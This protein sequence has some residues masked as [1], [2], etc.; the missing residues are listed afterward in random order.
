MSVY[1]DVIEAVATLI[2]N[3]NPYATVTI[4]AMPPTNGIA[5]AWASSFNRL[6]WDKKAAVEFSAVLNG[7]HSNQQT[8]ADGLSDIHTALNF[9]TAYPSADNFQITN[10]ETESAPSYIGR[11][12]NNQWLYGSSIR[13][14]FYLKGA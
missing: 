14:K 5:L 2:N 10:I 11:E 7:K 13:V 3:Q 4:G 1:S 12:E 8:V 6:F 9:M